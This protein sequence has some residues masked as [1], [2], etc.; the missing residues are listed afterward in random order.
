MELFKRPTNAAKDYQKLNTDTHEQLM[1]LLAYMFF[2]IP[3]I[4]K[5]VEKSEFV[6]YHTNQ[7][8]V[9]F[10]ATLGFGIVYLLVAVLIHY[11]GLSAWASISIGTSYH[12]IDV[13]SWLISLTWIGPLLVWGMGIRNVRAGEMKPLPLIG[14][15]KLIH[16]R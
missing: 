2:P 13:V 9:F 14:K 1:A 8:A 10:L 6:K 15:L 12:P 16:L 5:D 4:T 11:S 7:S 3:M